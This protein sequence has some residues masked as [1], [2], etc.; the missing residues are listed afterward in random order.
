VFAI[1]GLKPQAVMGHA[2]GVKLHPEK[3]CVK[4]GLAGLRSMLLSLLLG[5]ASALSYSQEGFVLVAG[6][7]TVIAA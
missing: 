5:T 6:H 3:V 7:A 4:C 2:L 1:L